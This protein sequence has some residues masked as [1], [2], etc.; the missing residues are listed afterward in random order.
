[1]RLGL[2]P[3]QHDR[4][5][6]HRTHPGIASTGRAITSSIY[7]R[8]GGP[9]PPLRCGRQPYGVLPVT[10]LD[11]W[12]P[13]AARSRLARDSGCAT[14][15]I[16]LRD[17]V[18]RPRLRRRAPGRRAPR[19]AR[20]RCRSGRRDAHRWLVE[21]LL[22]ARRVRPPLPAAS[23]RLPG[24][25]PAGGRLHRRPRMRWRRSCCS[26]SASPGGRGSRARPIADMAWRV[27]SPLVQ[28][29]EVSPWRMLE[30]N[31]IAAL[32]ALADDRRVDCCAAR[33]GRHR[34]RD[35]PAGG[36]AAPCAAARDRGC[37]GAD[38]RGR[39]GRRSR[40]RCCAMPSWSISSPAP[41]R[42]RPGGASST[43]RWPAV[44]G[45]R[46]IRTVSSKA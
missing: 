33:S 36:A 5:R 13:P 23:A 8:S 22:R 2:L 34:Q 44:T 29:G 37:R 16:G 20:S 7:V 6:R 14:L 17:N 28:H 3:H 10:S 32:L 40:D 19:S 38:R 35:Q 11:L 1:M 4:L 12:Q 45:T 25:G 27:A 31:Y 42:R 43:S 30:P 18:W 15:L 41:H 21:R 24:R 26:A 39:A 9:F 46:T